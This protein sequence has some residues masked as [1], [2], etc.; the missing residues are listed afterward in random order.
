VALGG[1]LLQDAERRHRGGRRRARAGERRAG[2]AL[3]RGRGRGH[4]RPLARPR[5]PHARRHGP[6]RPARPGGRRP[7][8]VRGDAGVGRRARAPPG[9]AKA[10]EACRRRAR[11]TAD[12]ARPAPA[13]GAAGRRPARPPRRRARAPR[14][15]PVGAPAPSARGP[16]VAAGGPSGREEGGRRP[17]G[18]GSGARPR[19][20]RLPPPAS[21][22]Q[23]TSTVPS[24][25][26]SRTI[27]QPAAG[28]AAAG[29]PGARARP[30][31]PRAR[32]GAGRGAFP[33][34][35]SP[36]PYACARE[37]RRP[38]L[39]GRRRHHAPRRRRDR[40]RRQREPPR[41][42]R[43]G[44]RDPPRRR[45]RDPRGVPPPRRLRDGRREGD[46]GGGAPGEVRDPRGRAGLARRRAGRGRPPRL[47]PPPLARARGR[48]RLRHGRVPG[49]L[50]RRL[51]LP[52][53]P[54]GA[55]RAL[56]DR[57]DARAARAGRA[58]HVRPLRARGARRLRGRAGRAPRRG[59]LVSPERD[60]DLRAVCF[61][62]LDVLQAKWGP[63]LR[64][65]ELAEGFSFRG[66]KV[67]FLN[68]AYGIY[69]AARGQRGPAALSL[70]SSP[71]QRRY[72]DEQ[73][74]EG[75]LYAYQG[76]DPD[77]HF[78]RLLRQA[79]LLRVPVV[80]FV[81]TRPNRYH[82]VYPAYVEEDFPDELRVL[83]TFGR[84]GG[85]Y[86]E[87]E[88]V[89]VEDPIERRYVVREVKQRI[90]QAHFRGRVL[91]A[92]RDRCAICR[93][94]ELR[95]LD[96]AHIVGDAQPAGEP[97]VSNGLSL[98]SIHHRAFDQ[99]LIGVSPDYEVRVSRRL[100]E[101]DDGPMLDPA[102]DRARTAD[103][104]AATGRVAPGPR[105]ARA[106]LRALQRRVR[107]SAAEAGLLRGLGGELGHVEDLVRGRGGDLDLGPV[108]A[109]VDR[110]LHRARAPADRPLV[111]LHDPA[112]EAGEVD[113]PAVVRRLD[114]VDVLAAD[115]REVA[116][117][118]QQ[119]ERLRRALARA[120]QLVE[121][122]PE[123]LARPLEV[124]PDP[125]LPAG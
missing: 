60:D 92:Y 51:R 105:A 90:H 120:H 24:S 114:A 122:D 100:L 40:Q 54:R 22:S 5:P 13:R 32:G 38:D 55:H 118:P 119:P 125:R 64:Y 48:A 107:A 29:R 74:P 84:M 6:R 67:P 80:Y 57:R 25:E 97:L 63:D 16:T 58:G 59:T 1:A 71:K 69:R 66:G 91:P 34:G 108:V 88:P 73:T 44:R 42:R 111:A 56:G 30:R 98:C 65:A 33:P 115:R 76:T 31:P 10:R 83:L 123:R 87:R 15:E 14:P 93:L 102:Q 50:D 78:N 11:R 4:G 20:H 12:E 116:A 109:E 79:H 43:R 124:D 23:R 86:D 26:R 19:R 36:T 106:A 27:R 7:R 89:H 110:D 2:E 104:P 49:D 68:R 70:M 41:R 75:V 8:P 37:G 81:G 18:A 121:V 95:L 117:G 99:H 113:G 17:A 82:P 77:N 94:K 21:S 112:H 101:D 3:A 35:A 96:A 52:A 62:S 39:P 45:A 46:D 72:R 53:R 85:P 103:R 47:V 61:A 28:R 9:G